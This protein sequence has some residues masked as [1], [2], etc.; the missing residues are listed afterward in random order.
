MPVSY[1]YR[2]YNSLQKTNL[3]NQQNESIRFSAIASVAAAIDAP[4]AAAALKSP[5]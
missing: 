5:K 1:I 3:K 4:A 2:K